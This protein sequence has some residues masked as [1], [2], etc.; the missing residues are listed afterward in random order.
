MFRLTGRRVGDAGTASMLGTLDQRT[1]EW[2]PAA[3]EALELDADRLSQPVRPGKAM[4][5]TGSCA[6]ALGLPRGAKVVVGGMDHHMAALGAGVGRLGQLSES[7]GTVLACVHPTAEFTPLAG[8]TS[9]PDV[10]SGYYHLNWHVNGANV[11][12]WYQSTHAPD[13]SFSQLTELAG[14]V[15]AGEGLPTALPCANQYPGLS[16][17]AEVPPRC[18][19]GHYV[20]AILEST[21]RSMAEIVRV[22]YP[23]T[24]PGRI[25]ATGGGARSELWLQT[26][27]DQLGCEVVATGVE[28]PAALGA[29][30]LAATAAG[31]FPSVADAGGA[32]VKARKVF[33]PSRKAGAS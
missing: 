8:T 33:A 29:A 12:A 6:Q 5:E 20:R 25:V 2:W 9:G 31:W 27:A 21:S 10:A 26:Y 15:G 3:L 16:G 32:W 18:E 23:S 1:L 14:A 11:L 30:M 13:M 22:F 28:E 17:F 19:H 4:G 24:P 7:T